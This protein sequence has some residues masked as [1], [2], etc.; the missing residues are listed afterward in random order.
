MTLDEARIVSLLK[1]LLHEADPDADTRD[2]MSSILLTVWAD[3]F[4]GVNV[5]GSMV[6]ISPLLINSNPESG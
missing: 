3:Q 1:D 6:L 5:W 4:D 2:P